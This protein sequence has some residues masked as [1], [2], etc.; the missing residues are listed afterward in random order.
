MIDTVSSKSIYYNELSISPEESVDF[1]KLTTDGRL[2]NDNDA[3]L[4]LTNEN[5][6]YID[7]T[8]KPVAKKDAVKL[9]DTDTNSVSQ[10]LIQYIGMD[11]ASEILGVNPSDMG[12][13]DEKTLQD[14]LG[15]NSDIVA[16]LSVNGQL[17]YDDLSMEQKQKLMGE[18]LMKQ[19]AGQ[20]RDSGKGWYGD[21]VAE[22]KVTD[23]WDGYS[24]GFDQSMPNGEYDKFVVD[25][26]HSRDAMSYFGSK[27]NQELKEKYNALDSSKYYKKDLDGKIINAFSVDK[28]QTVDNLWSRSFDQTMFQH[29]FFGSIQG[30]T[31][32]ADNPFFSTFGIKSK[33]YEQRVMILNQA[34]TLRGINLTSI[35]QD[36]SI[37]GWSKRWLTHQKTPASGSQYDWLSSDGCIVNTDE[38]MQFIDSNLNSWQLYNGFN[39]GTVINEDWSTLNRNMYGYH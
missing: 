26:V 21:T 36:P 30:N 16:R 6:D 2:I 38:N 10:A 28:V 18:L 5:G 31:L 22:F 39:M 29:P 14:V 17:S 35:G 24:I 34:T 32:A 12:N 3:D 4:Y 37:V 25:I 9:L 19:G 20:Q 8:G 15:M 23:N 13:Y 33:S 11:R 1:W 7:E 27:G